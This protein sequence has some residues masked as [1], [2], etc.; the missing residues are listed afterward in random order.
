MAAD[1]TAPGVPSA[2]DLAALTPAVAITLLV[3]VGVSITMFYIGPILRS[4]L[5]H[6]PAAPP[7]A[8]PAGDTTP[9]RH[10]LGPLD[11]AADRTQQFLDHLL[12]QIEQAA[13]REDELDQR[14]VAKDRQIDQLEQ[15]IQRLQ[16]MLWQ[17]E[18][19]QIH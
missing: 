18:R 16:T 9:G 10:T 1:Q 8:P 3:V 13:A 5:V 14:L 4:R 17:R 15:E 19:G 11:T 7:A 2:G 12:R 6:P